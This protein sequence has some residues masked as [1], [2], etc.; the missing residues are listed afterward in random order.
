MHEVLNNFRSLVVQ[1][2]DDRTTDFAGPLDDSLESNE[3]ARCKLDWHVDAGVLLG[4]ISAGLEVVGKTHWGSVFS[5]I[6]LMM[7]VSRTS[8]GTDES[9]ASSRIASNVKS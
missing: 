7:R 8:A 2:K 5:L 9:I 3:L 1:W 6:S 4:W